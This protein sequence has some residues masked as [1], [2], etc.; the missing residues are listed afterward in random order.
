MNRARL[1][2]CIA[3]WFVVATPVQACRMLVQWAPHIVEGPDVTEALWYR[4]VRLTA[5][6]ED[7]IAG[8][9]VE[10]F[11][12]TPAAA[13]VVRFP[14]IPDEEPHAICPMNFEVGKIYLL[15]LR[16]VPGHLQ[17]SRLHGMHVE[18]T[19][20]KFAVYVEDLRKARKIIKGEKK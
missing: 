6:D 1:A 7:G 10:S 2:L 3:G 14:F 16:E 8:E 4:V 9:M 19:H 11:G 17:I 12:A 13:G 15:H 18:S 5:V 20:D